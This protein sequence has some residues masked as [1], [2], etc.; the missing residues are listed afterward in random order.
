LTIA[1][2]VVIY[3]AIGFGLFSAQSP[4]TPQEKQ[5]DYAETIYPSILVIAEA[6]GEFGVDVNDSDERPTTRR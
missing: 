2:V 6:L 1:A 5:G 3:A 4:S